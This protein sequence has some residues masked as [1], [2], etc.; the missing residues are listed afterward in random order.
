MTRLRDRWDRKLFMRGAGAM[1]LAL[2]V[3]YFV[4]T[5]LPLVTYTPVRLAGLVRDHTPGDF[6]TKA[7]ETG[8]HL[9]RKLKLK[10][11][12]HAAIGA[13]SFAVQLGVVVAGGIGAIAINAAATQSAKA[14]RAIWL[15]AIALALNCLLA[16]ASPSGM[17]VPAFVTYFA[18]S[19]VYARTSSD[20]ALGKAFGTEVVGE[21]TP[22][23][24]MRRS[25]RRFLR[26]AFAAIIGFLVGGGVIAKMRT[27]NAPVSASIA[28]ADFP[29][30]KPA[31]DVGFDRIRGLTPEFTSN[32][33]FYNVDI[34]I[35]KPAINHET[36]RLKVR[37]LVVSPHEL[38]YRSMQSDF[39]VVEMPHTL[40]CISN[41]VGGDLISTTVWRG[42]RLRDV[43]KRAELKDGVI[44]I[45]FRSAE[46]YSDSISLDKALEETTLL[47][48][49]MNGVALPRE[50][51]FPARIIVPGIYGMKNV[52]WLT[53]I[54][55]TKTNYQGYWQVRG[56]SDLAEVKT[57]SRIDVPF[58][59]E[60]VTLDAAHPPRIAGVAWA[61]D[62]GIMRVEV[63][64]DAGVTWRPAVLKREISPRTW[65]LWAADIKPGKSGSRKVLVRATDGNGSTQEAGRT[66][67]HPDGAS[68]LDSVTFFVE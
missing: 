6:A 48:F 5:L 7:I 64:E 67:T 35:V 10:I 53:E 4:S 44:E 63:S 32:E 11:L 29:Y 57:Q 50:H 49:G 41:E 28:P 9:S 61:G 46:G 51:G 26:R 34:N 16:L 65:R 56:W 2:V 59:S 42:V 3:I 66:K 25:R 45:I 24:A 55:A 68:G 1:V 20:V 22:L 8:V 33:D 47:V 15:L 40:S 43:L 37:G 27:S 30:E 36:W 12:E 38:D 54:E 14:K 52:K 60:R 39:P 18:A 13:L 23:D 19:L 31:S 21:E 58:D 17:N 62:R